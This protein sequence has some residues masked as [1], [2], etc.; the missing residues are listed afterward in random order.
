MMPRLKSSIQ[1]QIRPMMT[2]GSAQGTMT[3]ARASH[4]H[5]NFRFSSSAAARPSANC[6]PTATTTQTNERPRVD[7]NAVVVQHRDVV[8]QANEGLR[9][10]AKQHHI[11]QRQP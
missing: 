5:E 9:A 8:R 7:Q 6:A 1:V 10:R 4:R 3:S 2:L 11:M